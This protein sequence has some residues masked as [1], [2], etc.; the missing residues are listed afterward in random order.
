MLAP[1]GTGLGRVEMQMS[2]VKG[3]ACGERAAGNVE[4]DVGPDRDRF[5]A[6]FAQFLLLVNVDDR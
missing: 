4:G 6:P 5:A 3:H 2:D 1:L